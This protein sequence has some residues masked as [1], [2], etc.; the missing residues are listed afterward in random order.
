[1]DKERAVEGVIQQRPI[2]AR[3]IGRQRFKMGG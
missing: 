3:R 2:A 1:M